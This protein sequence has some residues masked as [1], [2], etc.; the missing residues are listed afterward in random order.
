MSVTKNLRDSVLTLKDK[1]V[2]PNTL[3]VVLDEGNLSFTEENPV[4]QIDDRGIQDHLRKGSNAGFDFSWTCKFVEFTAASVTVY[5]FLKGIG[6]AS[7]YTY[8]ADSSNGTLKDAGDVKVMHPTFVITDPVS[9][10][11]TLTFYNSFLR[12]IKFDEGSDYNTLAV[13]M[14]CC[15]PA[16]VVS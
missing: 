7:A 4:I 5:E 6:N 15:E 14:H 3:A 13:T 9:G 16:P 12:N 1:A 8:T 11:E 2:S 10:T